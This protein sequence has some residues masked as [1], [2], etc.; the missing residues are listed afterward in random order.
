[1]KPQIRITDPKEIDISGIESALRSGK[2][3]IVQF[4]DDAYTD[5]MLSELNGLS[6]RYDS[7]FGIRFFGHYSVAFS[8]KTLLKIPSV[9]SLYIDCVTQANDISV[10]SELEYL[11]SLALGVFELTDTEILNAKNFRQLH[12]LILSETRT[13]AL[14]LDHLRYYKNLRSL[15][16]NGH[17]K[18]IEAVSCLSNLKFLSLNLPKKTSVK[19]VND[20]KHLKTLKFILGGRENISEIEENNIEVLEIVWVRGFNDLGDTSRFKALR[21]LLLENN[22]QLKELR[23]DSEL[24]YLNDLKILN[25][26]SL[27]TLLGLS[28]LPS[29]NQLRIYQT[30]ID[31]HHFKDEKFPKALKT[32]AFYTTNKKMDTEINAELAHRGYSE[33]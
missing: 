24:R 10:L 31:F 5:N 33:F 1:M 11:Q 21:T 18:N 25:C 3:I 13:K 30:N 14:N 19:F 12:T 20:L 29:L 32:F 6:E 17:T 2:H 7:A 26:K 16:L 28:N 15:F 4:S 23:F 27:H 22:V 9:K 8:C